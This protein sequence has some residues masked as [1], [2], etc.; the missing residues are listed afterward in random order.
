MQRIEVT[1]DGVTVTSETE[2]LVSVFGMEMRP[3]AASIDMLRWDE[4]SS[5]SLSATELAPDGLR[6]ISLTVDTTWGEYYEVHE[7]AEGFEDAV[8]HL[9]N[10]SGL[11]KSGVKNLATGRHLIWRP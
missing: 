2:P 1:G 8:R 11:P 4:I 6:W 9:C 3:G 5:V 7:G 10:S